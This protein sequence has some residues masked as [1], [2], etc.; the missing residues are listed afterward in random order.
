MASSAALAA[1]QEIIYTTRA[2]DTLLGLEQRYLSAPFGWKNIKALNRIGDPMRIPVGTPVRLYERWLRTE[3]RTAR[4]VALSGDVTLDGRPLGMDAR[5]AAGAVLRTG[6]GAFVTLS[7][8][9]DS[10]LTVQPG[11]EAHLEKIQG[12]HGLAGQNTRILLEQGRLESTVTPQR[13]PAARYQIRTPTAS[14]AVRGTAFRV[15]SDSDSAAT[16]AE[17]TKGEIGM[18]APGSPAARALPAGFGVLALKGQPIPAPKALLPAP[19]LDGVPALFERVDMQVSFPPVDKAVAYR[20]QI[21][22]DDQFNDVVASEVFNTPKARFIGLPD[23]AYRLR[24]RAIDAEG[25]EGFDATLP[26]ELRA[27]PVPPEG[28]SAAPGVLAWTTSPDASRFRLQIGTDGSFAGPLVDMQIEGLQAAPELAPGHYTWRIASLRPDDS[29]GPWSDIRLLELRS[30]PG[31]ITVSRYNDR[32]RFAWPAR[33]GQ[34][35]EFQ[36]ARDEGF[37]ELVADQ[38]I[39]EAAV[40]LPAPARGRYHLRIRATD[41]DGVSSPWS[42]G[43]RL[44]SLFLL[45]YW[46]LSAPA[47]KLP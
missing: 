22:R 4:V 37:Q 20:A 17:V 11:S 13:G 16:R 40:T 10:R 19:S 44:T 45:P 14:L 6:A 7:M 42:P 9:D 21:A 32:L 12:F 46:V 25:L 39:G 5:V 30:P 35:Y 38:R 36:L 1:D 28:V 47:A 33:P 18:D 26:I 34:I 29:R 23:G 43:Q 41:P 15:G 2:G 8:P 3:P 31:P 24:V 27:R